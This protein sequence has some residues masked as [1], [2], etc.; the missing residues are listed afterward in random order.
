MFSSAFFVQVTSSA[1]PLRIIHRLVR[2]DRAVIRC[3]FAQSVMPHLQHDYTHVT[4]ISYRDEPF[5]VTLRLVFRDGIRLDDDG[6]V[7]YETKHRGERYM[8]W[9]ST[10]LMIRVRLSLVEIQVIFKEDSLHY[11]SLLRDSVKQTYQ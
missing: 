6:Y 9:P 1:S 4:T 8:C 10:N 7:M 11:P 2:P 5:K 3:A